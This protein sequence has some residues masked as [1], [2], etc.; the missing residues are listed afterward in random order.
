MRF[1]S[2]INRIYFTLFFLLLTLAGI[3]LYVMITRISNEEVNEKMLADEERIL[4]AIK[5]G[6]GITSLPPVLEVRPWPQG[7]SEST[8]IKDTSLFDPVE[9]EVELFR[10]ISS[11]RMA[12]GRYWKII[13]RQMILEPHDYFMS[14]GMAL[15]LVLVLL[16]AFILILNQIVLGRLWKPFR[17]NLSRLKSFSVTEEKPLAL[18]AS[19]ITEFR[20]LNSSLISLSDRVLKDYQSL[21]EY[22]ENASHE[23]QTPLAVIQSQLEMIIQDPALSEEQAGHLDIIKKTTQRLSRLNRQLLLLMKVENNQYPEVEVL[24]I[25]GVLREQL[26]GFSELIEA[27]HLTVEAELDDTTEVK[28]NRHLLE[29]LLTN[30][31]SNA[32]KHNVKDGEI[33]L[34]LSAGSLNVIN[35]GETGGSQT[36]HLFE[37]FKK[38]RQASDSPGLGLAIVKRICEHYQWQ[39]GYR[40]ES[41]RHILEIRF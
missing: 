28:A 15:V 11:V 14:I 37:R 2:R 36:D 18:A 33:I 12:A 38:S 30:L 24:E 7:Q 41:D 31:L 13:Q 27:K 40:I 34:R 17:E 26:K 3:S 29:I 32:V 25:S 9:G 16:L 20:E 22:T 39:V 4:A 21:K 1:L 35:T 10:E 23:L 8:T 6:T 19:N 5:Q